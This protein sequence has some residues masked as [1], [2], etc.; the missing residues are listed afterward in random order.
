MGIRQTGGGTSDRRLLERLIDVMN[1]QLSEE[2]S[3]KRGGGG[4][5]MDG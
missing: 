2:K 4:A 1:D 5:N 3:E